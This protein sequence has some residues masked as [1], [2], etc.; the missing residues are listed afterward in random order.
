MQCKRFFFLIPILFLPGLLTAQT[1]APL[2]DMTLNNLVLP[3]GYITGPIGEPGKVIKKGKG[4]KAMILVPGWGFGA[5]VFNNFTDQYENDYRVYAVTLPGFGGTAAP[6]MPAGGSYEKHEWIHN[7]VKG[8]LNLIDREKLDRPV[9][10][11]HFYV[12]TQ[13]ALELGLDHADKIGKLILL[14]GIPHRYYRPFTDTA[15]GKE[16][17]F[18]TAERTRIVNQYWAPAWYKTVTKETWD[19]GNHAPEEYSKDSVTGQQLFAL[20][21]AVPMPVMIRYLLEFFTYDVSAR[22]KEI[23]IP[24]LVLLPSF[25]DDFFNEQYYS[26][27]QTI[28]REWTKYYYREVW[29]SAREAHNP[30]IRI[31]TI[32]GTHAFLWYDNPGATYSMINEF[33]SEKKQ[34]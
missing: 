18:T 4:K 29:N 28:S 34:Y 7:A 3:A 23:R 13:V 5:E 21:A 9:I 26:A 19:S 33:I 11:A 12:A 2:Q 22:Y 24:M 27:G 32:P 14:S 1:R 30:N 31:E 6:P 10:V 20:S 16:A 17:R 8:I 15:W 25:S